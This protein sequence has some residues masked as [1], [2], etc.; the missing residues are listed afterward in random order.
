MVRLSLFFILIL[1]S[2]G[3]SENDGLIPKGKFKNI[4]LE[5][6]TI[7]A[8]YQMKYRALGI[9][10]DSLK[11]SVDLVLKKNGVSF[12]QYER[13]YRHYAVRQKELREI[14]T[15]LVRKLEKN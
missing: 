14:N 9:Y 8:A 5:I 2:C 3:A 1:L 11:K 15:D 6:L 10:K 13:T 12:D 4:H 7:E